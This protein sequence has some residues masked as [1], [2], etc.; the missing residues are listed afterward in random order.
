[1]SQEEILCINTVH[2]MIKVSFWPV[3]FPCDQNFGSHFQWT[4]MAGKPKVFICCRHTYKIRLE[5]DEYEQLE[6]LAKRFQNSAENPDP[7]YIFFKLKADGVF[8]YVATAD[9]VCEK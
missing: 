2:N 8:Y 4:S 7:A 1:M 3:L 6:S 9:E 5:V